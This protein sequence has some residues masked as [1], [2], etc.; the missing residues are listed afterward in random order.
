MA[1][2]LQIHSAMAFSP[3]AMLQMRPFYRDFWDFDYP[4]RIMDQDFGLGL[5]DRDLLP[6]VMYRGYLIRP[7]TEGNVSSSGSSEVV[8]DKEKFQV[9]LNVKQFKPEE[10]SVKTVDNC[11]VIRG[12]HEEKQ[13]EHG[14]ISREFTRRYMLPQGVEPETVT[15][16][17]SPDGIL[18]ISAPKKALE[19]S[20]EN[21]RVVP[22]TMQQPAAVES[23][24]AEGG[25]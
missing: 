23:P 18:T 13:D 25:Q 11:I 8:S 7:R 5:L 3:F 21:E 16:S 4:H 22:I 9:L 15:S 17:L 14:F 19:P 1:F 12:K 6:P 20:P 24:K 2:D 10:I